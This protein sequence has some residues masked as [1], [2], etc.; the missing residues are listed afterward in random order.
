MENTTEPKKEVELWRID[1]LLSEDV[2]IT[3]DFTLD[4]IADQN[5]LQNLTYQDQL[6]QSL[7]NDS[8][9]SGTYHSIQSTNTSQKLAIIDDELQKN[10]L[11]AKPIPMGTSMYYVS[12]FLEFL[13]PLPPPL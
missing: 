8:S 12:R 1:K 3:K 9:S 13:T 11:V 6:S 5:E 2:M 10:Q 4:T 7:G